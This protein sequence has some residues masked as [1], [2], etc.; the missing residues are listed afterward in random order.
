MPP[1]PARPLPPPASATAPLLA[2]TA[3]AATESDP[4]AA[5]P[6]TPPRP[7]AEVL[8]CS[9]GSDDGGD[10]RMAVQSVSEMARSQ[11]GNGGTSQQAVR[12]S[13]WSASC[14]DSGTS[15]LL[16][17]AELSFALFNSVPFLP[18][19]TVRYRLP[20]ARDCHS[21]AERPRGRCMSRA[22]AC[23]TGTAGDDFVVI[24]RHL[25]DPASLPQQ[26]YMENRVARAERRGPNGAEAKYYQG[27]TFGQLYNASLQRTFKFMQDILQDAVVFVAI[28]AMKSFLVLFTVLHFFFSCLFCFRAAH[29]IGLL[30]RRH[31][32]LSN[33]VYQLRT[34]WKERKVQRQ[35][36]A[37]F[38]RR[39]Q[40]SQ[41]LSIRVQRHVDWL[42]LHQF[43]PRDPE[44][45]RRNAMTL[46][47][48]IM[49]EMSAPPLVEHPFFRSF[50]HKHPKLL[51]QLC[52]EALVPVF[53]CS[54]EVVFTVGESCSMMYV[55]ISG[56]SQYA[57]QLPPPR[58]SPAG[59]PGTQVRKTLQSGQWLSEAALW[60]GWVHRGELRTLCDC[61]FFG[62]E[63]GRFAR[64]ISSQKSAHAFA[65]SYARFEPEH[66]VRHHRGRTC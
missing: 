21:P 20:A 3:T 56:Q 52:C 43:R 28:G 58:D 46:V 54:P 27:E 7:L 1:Q 2:A 10:S 9:S 33:L 36:A 31:W 14:F 55:I 41:L 65:A 23:R 30:T 26:R 34:L 63:A 37:D 15:L 13:L 51:N 49:E 38:L 61:L 22:S 44:K 12:L 57:A 4:S 59:T 45:A 42:Q 19:V 18:S 47:T 25:A 48:E 53:H 24:L 39:H 64:V 11:E 66:P 60:T 29:K 8:A 35:I 16:N 6:P 40:T 50:R 32:A 17:S 62:L 5:P